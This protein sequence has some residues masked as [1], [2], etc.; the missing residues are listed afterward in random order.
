MS[1]ADMYEKFETLVV[2]LGQNAPKSKGERE[3]FRRIFLRGYENGWAAAERVGFWTH[4]A[5]LL[6]L[7]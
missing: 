5:R 6:R 3:I 7:Q 2:D 1:K 4:F